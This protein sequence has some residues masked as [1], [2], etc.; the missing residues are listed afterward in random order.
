MCR[1]SRLVVGAAHAAH[2]LAVT[3]F[4][5]PHSKQVKVTGCCPG[6]VGGGRS[7]H[8]SFFFRRDSRAKWRIESSPP[9]CALTMLM[10]P[11]V[12]SLEQPFSIVREDR[13]DRSRAGVRARRIAHDRCEIGPP[14]SGPDFTS[15]LE[16]LT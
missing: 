15:I 1:Y 2:A 14:Y 6:T 13:R 16:Q 8:G 9:S 3:A 11:S 12:R 4:C 5:S 7:G 10:V